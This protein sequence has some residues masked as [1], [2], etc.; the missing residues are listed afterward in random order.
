[1]L[2]IFFTI[3]GLQLAAIA[4]N[5]LRSK[6]TAVLLGPA[7]VGIISVIDQF[8]V[9]VAQVTALGLPFAAIKALARS[10]SK[11]PGAFRMTYSSLLH[12]LALV[13]VCGTVVSLTIL[14]W[15]PAWLGSELAGYRVVLFPALMSVPLFALH[16]YFTNVLAAAQETRASA[17][18]AL[19]IAGAF[20]ASTY[21][22]IVVAGIPGLYWA[23]F[24]AAAAVVVL[25]L[26]Y[27]RWRLGLPVIDRRG[28]IAAELRQH[29]DVITFSLIHYVTTFA[30]SLSFLVARYATLETLG[31]RGAGIL[32]AALALALALNLL[33]SPVNGLYLTPRLN[34]E[35][36][37]EEK[38][39]TTLDFQRR[40]IPIMGALTVPIVLIPQWIIALLYS[41]AFV[42]A[43][44]V[45]F[46]LIIAQY[47]R[48]LAGVYQA[49]L[50]GLDDLM[51]YGMVVT[52]GHLSFAL[53]AWVL[54][55]HF[56]MAGV[57][58]GYLISSV[59][60]F[61]VTLGRLSSRHGLRPPFELHALAA[62]GLLALSIIG[63]AF[64]RGAAGDLFV[65]AG[66][67]GVYLA[68]IAGLWMFTRSEDRDSLIQG[69]K[70]LRA[71]LV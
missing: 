49:L 46:V 24:V 50:I 32:Q 12:A 19:V 40:L 67:A 11:D 55:P 59:A 57:A 20:A 70:R 7:G 54:A 37:K 69:L 16:G 6:I 35:I 71:R 28:S 1:M 68:F 29:R 58:I 53:L 4:M 8:A 34:R 13:T 31:P 60:M 64:N 62:Y 39:R 30:F 10:H 14:L 44:G 21:V 5:V 27:L 51:V 47:L 18:L 65:L 23:N 17:L 26:A 15:R 3:G 9:T 66:K 63:S 42:S 61:A 45:V 36:A 2:A 33:L 38:L 41:S 22:G 43:A 25:V 56:G 48:Q 52:A